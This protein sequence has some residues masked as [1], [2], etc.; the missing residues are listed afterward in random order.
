MLWLSTKFEPLKLNTLTIYFYNFNS[1][2]DLGAPIILG[3]LP[4][5]LGYASDQVIA[6]F[7]GCL[8]NVKLNDDFV[9]FSNPIE[10]NG[11]DVEACALLDGPCQS[12]P[13]SNGAT[14]IGLGNSFQCR[15]PVQFSGELCE[16][17]TCLILFCLSMHVCAHVCVLYVY[18][19][20]CLFVTVCYI[21]IFAIVCYCDCVKIYR[22]SFSNIF[23]QQ[24]YS[25]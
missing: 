9:D 22:G 15:C 18:T 24:L 16:E 23:W 11:M 14:C 7:T 13:C 8:R 3:G 10:A 2:L 12:S 19:Y 4:A 5:S 21:R 17:R 25:I 6:P 1:T 20:V